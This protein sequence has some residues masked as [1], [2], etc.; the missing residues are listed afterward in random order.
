MNV[1]MKVIGM[2]NVLKNISSWQNNKVNDS[3]K[4]ALNK[5][6]FKI[7]TT[8]KQLCPVDT[9][10]LRASIYSKMTGDLSAIVGDKVQYGIYLEKGTRNQRPQPFLMPAVQAHKGEFASSLKEVF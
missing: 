3:V 6:R 10:R 4:N 2:A 7:E 1:S 9:G 5:T 8:A